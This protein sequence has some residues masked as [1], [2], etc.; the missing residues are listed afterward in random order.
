MQLPPW[1]DVRG[2]KTHPRASIYWRVAMNGRQER[3]RELA[4]EAISTYEEAQRLA[5]EARKLDPDSVREALEETGKN[6]DP[7]R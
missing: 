2:A 4:E 1:V 6:V 3:A 5:E 7:I